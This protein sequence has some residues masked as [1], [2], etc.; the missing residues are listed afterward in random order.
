[1]GIPTKYSGG[2]RSFVNAQTF[3][4]IF[5][6]AGAITFKQC[7]LRQ[8]EPEYAFL[9]RAVAAVGERPSTQETRQIHTVD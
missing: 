2:T 7:S 3:T 9:I 1:L 4:G 5:R 8:A 6:T